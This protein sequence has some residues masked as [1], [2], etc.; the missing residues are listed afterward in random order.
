MKNLLVF[1]KKYN[2]AELCKNS[3]KG[4]YF[5]SLIL[6]IPLVGSSRKGLEILRLLSQLKLNSYLKVK[7]NKILNKEEGINKERKNSNLIWFCWLQGIE[8]APK[9]VQKCFRSIEK[10]PGWKVVLITKDNYGNY[11]DLPKYISDKWSQGKISNTHFSDILRLDLLVRNGG[12]WIDS[13][14]YFTGDNIPEFISNSELFLFQ[15]LKPGFN[16]HTFKV[17]SW[18]IFSKSNNKILSKTRELIFEY[19]KSN[20]SLIDYFLVHHFLTLSMD[21]YDELANQIPKFPNSIPHILLLQIFEPFNL[22]DFNYIT[23]L[24][25]FHKLSYKRNKDQLDLNGTYYKYIVDN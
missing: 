8:N 2:L 3:I 12:L 16:G 20:K 4:G 11:T 9:L 22:D 24:C 14:V 21:K 1:F 17:S 19:W 25:P 13:T 15:N 18:L 10:I 7:Y 23:N 5:I 6:S